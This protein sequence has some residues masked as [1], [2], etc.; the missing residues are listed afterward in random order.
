MIPWKTP[1]VEVLNHASSVR[2]DV[3]CSLAEADVETDPVEPLNTGASS[4]DACNAPACPSVTPP[5]YVPFA[6]LDATSDAVV[7]LVSSSGQYPSKSGLA[8]TA[9]K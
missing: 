8:V 1:D 3:G 7:P 5:L 4:L 9:P 2:L 6:G